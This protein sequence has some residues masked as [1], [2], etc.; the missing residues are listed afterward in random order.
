MS[1]E[2]KHSQMLGQIACLVE[3]FAHALGFLF[4]RLEEFEG[5]VEAVLVPLWYL[6]AHLALPEDKRLAQPFDGHDGFCFVCRVE[7]GLGFR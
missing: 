2:Q 4:H 7:G 5:A 1:A 3:E 6:I